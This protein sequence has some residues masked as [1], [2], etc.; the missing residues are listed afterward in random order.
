MNL[1][2]V[3]GI[4]LCSRE[5]RR[6]YIIDDVQD[7]RVDKTHRIVFFERSGIVEETLYRVG[8]TF[9]VTHHQSWNVYYIAKLDCS[10][11]DYEL[12]V[13]TKSVSCARRLCSAR[14][15]ILTPKHLRGAIPTTI[16]NL[17]KFILENLLATNMMNFNGVSRARRVENGRRVDSHEPMRIVERIVVVRLSQ[18]AAVH[19]VCIARTVAGMY[20]LINHR[21]DLVMSIVGEIHGPHLDFRSNVIRHGWMTP[22]ELLEI[23]KIHK[24]KMSTWK[25]ERKEK[26][27]R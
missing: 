12:P 20:N 3:S 18:S 15:V 22:A 1:T 27:Q 7:T 6:H 10:R 8:K 9:F 4:E 21:V 17:S 26:L 23:R 2:F 16:S 24:R 14:Q 25:S 5:V 13:N 11:R 19:Y